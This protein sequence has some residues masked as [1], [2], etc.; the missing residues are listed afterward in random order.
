[1]LMRLP[2][3]F[4]K[5]TAARHFNDERAAKIIW[6]SAANT[7]MVTYRRIDA[8]SV[9]LGNCRTLQIC[10]KSYDE[11]RLSAANEI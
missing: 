9:E 5:K 11:R 1:M 7:G 8:A 6:W 4:D 10:Y 2:N 3:A